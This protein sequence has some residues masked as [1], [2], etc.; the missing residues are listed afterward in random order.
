[1]GGANVID[2]ASTRLRGSG[3]NGHEVWSYCGIKDRD[4]SAYRRNRPG[5]GD[6]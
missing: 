6:V 1:L 4:I 5:I 2:A 3:F